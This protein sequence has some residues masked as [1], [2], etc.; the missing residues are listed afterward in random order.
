MTWPAHSPSSKVFGIAWRRGSSPALWS[1]SLNGCP[2]TATP[3][4]LLSISVPANCKRLEV[5]FRNERTMQ[6]DH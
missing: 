1:Y 3:V 5:K 6:H 4:A 2:M